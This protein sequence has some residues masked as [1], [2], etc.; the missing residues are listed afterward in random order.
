MGYAYLCFEEFVQV[1]DG[2]G[3]GKGE[4][5]TSRSK[6]T[7]ID[8]TYIFK[9]SL[10]ERDG[11]LGLLDEVILCVLN[12]ELCLLLLR[13]TCGLQPRTNATIRVKSHEYR[14]RVLRLLGRVKFE[15]AAA[16]GL[17]GLHSDVDRGRKCRLPRLEITPLDRI[18]L[19]NARSSDS[20]PCTRI[21]AECPSELIVVALW[22][23][24]Q[25]RRRVGRR[26][27]ERVG[28]SLVL[29]LHGGDRLW[30]REVGPLEVGG[31]KVGDAVSDGG[32]Q[33][34]D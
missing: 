10:H 28:E 22:R 1:L 14:R 15:S 16:H 5:S 21:Q 12:V 29:S 9:H 2:L 20:L 17:T 31:C 11:D 34:C 19:F 7:R 8:S 27:T 3:L 33:F 26:T 18:V 6:K 24:V 4:T 25:H 23:G 13:R 32:G 30:C